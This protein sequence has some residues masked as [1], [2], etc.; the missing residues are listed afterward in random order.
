[1]KD[2]SA[3]PALGADGSR[4]RAVHRSGTVTRIGSRGHGAAVAGVCNGR[5]SIRVGEDRWALVKLQRERPSWGI[6][7]GVDRRATLPPRATCSAG[8]L[9]A[10]PA[11][12]SAR[13]S[14]LGT[15]DEATRRIPVA[16]ARLGTSPRRRPVSSRLHTDKLPGPTG[17]PWRFGSRCSEHGDDAARRQVV[18]RAG[19]GSARPAT[20]W[21]A[22]PVAAEDGA[23]PSPRRRAPSTT[24]GRR[25][26]PTAEAITPAR[27]SA[28]RRRRPP[29]VPDAIDRRH[30]HPSGDHPRAPVRG[31]GFVR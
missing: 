5:A 9:G 10:G 3:T 17:Q 14:R 13:R 23:R 27:R 20:R 24:G 22:A 31:V 25:R 15:V 16:I 29:G 26:R 30:D 6:D 11:A 12:E 4:L 2:R 8:P 21:A 19:G 1:M 18:V 7:A 28:A